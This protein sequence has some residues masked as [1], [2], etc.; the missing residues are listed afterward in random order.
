MISDAPRLIDIGQKSVTKRIWLEPYNY[1]KWK[2]HNKIKI[3]LPGWRESLEGE[4]P[5]CIPKA[6]PIVVAFSS[7]HLRADYFLN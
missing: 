2:Q 5:K 1:H 4:E 6:I 7:S 3:C